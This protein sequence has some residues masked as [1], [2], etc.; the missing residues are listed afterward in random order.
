MISNIAPSINKQTR[1]GTIDDNAKAWRNIAN[2]ARAERTFSVRIGDRV[3]AKAGNSGSFLYAAV[4]NAGRANTNLFPRSVDD[5]ANHS[6]VRIPAS[7]PRIVRVTDHV[8][9]RRSFAAQHT[10]RHRLIPLCYEI[11]QVQNV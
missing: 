7:P 8:S 5:R 4:A 6:K 10:L 9:E 11:V 1:V 3:K 2:A